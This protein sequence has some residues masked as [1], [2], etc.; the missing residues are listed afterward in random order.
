MTRR[1]RQSPLPIGLL[2]AIAGMALL[3]TCTERPTSPGESTP[4]P[5]PVSTPALDVGPGTVVLV[6]AGNVARCDGT[7][8]DRTATLLDGIEG[9]V[10]TTGD[11]VHSGGTASNYTNCYGG[12]WGRH[13]GRTR[14]SA[15]DV[16]YSTGDAAAYFAYFGAAAGEAGKGYYSY[17]LGAWHIVV[18]NNRVPMTVGSAQEV[19]LKADLAAT[20]QPCVLAYWHFPRFSSYS[21]AV[22]SEVKPLWDALYAAQAD[23][24]VNGHY[25]LYERF[26][27]QTPTGVADPERGIRQFTV[28]T[29]GHGVDSFTSVR[30]NSEVR[31]S[32]T[33]G[34][35]KLSLNGASYDWQF[36]PVAG[37]TFTDAGTTGCHGR[38]GGPP[39]PPPPPAN[40]APTAHAGGPY[41]SVGPV[42]FDGS[43]S[44]DPDNHLPLTFAWDFGD[45]TTG[46]GVAPSHTYGTDATFTASLVVTDAQGLPSTPATATVNVNFPPTV[47][48]GND[49]E[50]ALGAPFQLNATV[51]DPGG[52]ADSPWRWVI[53][54][55]DGT[56]TEGEIAGLET[57][58]AASHQYPVAGD[59]AVRVTVTDKDG[60]TATDDVAVKVTATTDVPLILVGAGNVARCDG[61]NDDRTATLLDGI[62]G[63]VFTTGDNV[64]SGGTASNYTNCYGGSWGRHKGRTRPSAGDV[65]YSTGDAAAY[66]AYFGAA[67]GE[68]GKGY[69]SY[70]LGAWHIVVLNNR[71]PMTVGSAQEVWL[72]AD[73][74]AT[75]QPCVLAYWHFP[76]FSS[77]STAV[78]SEVKPLWDALYAAQADV[79]VNGHYR[80]YERF[81]LQTPTGV[82][83]PERG[84]RQFTV[85]TGGHGVDSFTSVR[86]NSEVRSSGT[87]GV[88]KLS[89]NGA[90]YD[91]QFVPVAGQTFTDA[92]TTGC[93]GRPGGPPPPPPPPN[94]P[95]VATM[96]SPTEGATYQGGTVFSFSGSASDPEEGAL[97]AARLTWWA[98]FHHDTHTHPFLPV[99]TGVASGTI[100]V[101]RV[102]ETADNV[103]YR[104]YLVAVDAQGRADTVIRDIQ[105]E[106]TTL[107]LATA[108]AGLQ[109]TLDGQPRTTPLTV[110]GV[111]G[112]EREL[113]VVS[114]QTVG[115]TTYTF[116]SWSDA[117]AA[118]HTIITPGS[119]I[120]YTATYTG[121]APNSPPAV[122]LTAPTAGASAQVNTPVSVTAS[123]SDPDAGG[124]VTEVVFFDG[125]T[126]IGTDATSPY[127]VTWTPVTTG[128]RTL[129]A[130]A[131]DDRGATTISVGV[132]F[133]V[134]SAPGPDMEAPTAAV[135]SPSN[136]AMGLT[137]AL[138]LR[139]T[140][141]D[142]VGV[143]GVEFQV[144]GRQ[145]GAEDVTEPYEVVLPATN[146]YTTGIHVIRARARDAAGN[147]SPWATS[148]VTFGGSVDLPAGFSRTIY[149]QG[150]S[151]VTAMAFAPDGR[152]FICQQ[153]GQIRVVPAGGG[154]PLA[155]PFHT[156]NVTN[157]GEQGLLGIAFHPNFAS[158]GWVYV[159]Y[160]SPTPTNHNRISRVVANAANPNVST[161]AETFMLDDL[162]TVGTGGNHNG[163]AIHFSPIDGK[164]YVAI[165][166]QG[167]GS[168]SQPLTTRFGKI[169]R[170]NDDFTIPA[171]NPFLGTTTGVFRAIWAHGLRNPFT[172]AFQPG[173]G[174]MFINDVGQNAWEEI[175][176]GIA[177]SNYGWPITEG[178]TTDP[179]F[180]SPVF[181]YEHRSGAILRG[182]AVVGG[183]W[184]NPPNPRLPSDH[185]GNYFFADYV[186]G[187][188]NRLDPNAGNAVYAFARTGGQ[189]VFD[190]KV[191]PDGALYALARGA[192]FLVYRYQSP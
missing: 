176:E 19:W 12:S 159:Y 137:G 11:N 162:P 133:T 104:F 103:W 78:R 70:D 174:R 33:Y 129:T 116:S 41:T 125:T 84:I 18:L 154:A 164:L 138:T 65:D 163:G 76:R 132:A 189:D 184:Y 52:G 134:T 45:G 127:S 185:L 75:T 111:V 107:T 156:F 144:D 79:V 69:Y 126:P 66:F 46:T 62:E 108:P 59:F 136:L 188:I 110:T 16:D 173:T 81:G 73:L 88:L 23:V 179:R 102:G 9:T 161:G 142:N 71:V 32:G 165:G 13:K 51:G 158:N 6:G 99:T 191:G 63:T 149:T 143:V 141:G 7:N 77:Y 123:A 169:L 117:G 152:L 43:V 171:D 36:V 118:S 109:V 105:P 4:E 177:G 91:W 146:V 190:L 22:R 2:P 187:W 113:G 98:D 42:T 87:Y 35:L 155:T 112:I 20:T 89:L 160:T 192:T 93:H 37:Q 151:A 167:S 183:T 27:L 186:E 85:G 114:P 180:R 38:P 122:S 24:V 153:N 97:A 135:T 15:G 50:V 95:P 178:P 47:A 72:K 68:A 147:V 49:A 26:G 119:A 106:K 8:D 1:V 92:G 31:S 182:F 34:V 170:Y 14:P 48:A 5:A 60:A 39:P 53:A 21:T 30:P 74:A 54:W 139:A 121:T 130:R 148:T 120:T 157:S 67:A 61:T 94:E 150:L 80:L 10:F 128:V 64:H 166:D 29:G 168:T 101:P 140:A 124:S 145:I 3:T 181:A 17:D 175:N 25:R 83:D 56:T 172:F 100:T 90:S 58:I 44:A 28:G 40:Q 96:V 131:T 86:P 57:P 55:G 82:A 115:Q